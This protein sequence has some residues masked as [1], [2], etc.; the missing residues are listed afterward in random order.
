MAAGIFVAPKPRRAVLFDQDIMH[1]VSAPLGAFLL[2]TM[3]C[4]WVRFC[5][6]LG[7]VRFCHLL[8]CISWA[9]GTWPVLDANRLTCPLTGPAATLFP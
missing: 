2:F 5:H 9:R 6:L 7:W 3:C 4:S 1:R 8:R